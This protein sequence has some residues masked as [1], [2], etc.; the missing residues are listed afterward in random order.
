MMCSSAC[1]KRENL[2]LYFDIYAFWFRYSM[3]AQVNLWTKVEPAC[4]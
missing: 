4:N 1:W 2:N 3:Y